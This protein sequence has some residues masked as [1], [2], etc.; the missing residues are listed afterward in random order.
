MTDSVT[1]YLTVLD[2]IEAA[3]VTLGGEPE[4]RDWGLL[5][6]AL[7]RPEATVFGEEAY[8]TLFAKAAALLSSIVANHALVDGNKRLGW[9]CTR[10]FLIL[11]NSDLDAPEDD[12]YDLVVAVAAGQIREVNEIAALLERWAV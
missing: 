11:N 12:A 2:V 3:T 8:P 10:L 6:S 4:V 9:V 1:D 7:V 5:E